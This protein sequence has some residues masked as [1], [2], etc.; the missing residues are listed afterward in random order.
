MEPQ[1]P[2]APGIYGGGAELAAAHSSKPCT[3]GGNHVFL[4]L[5]EQEEVRSYYCIDRNVYFELPEEV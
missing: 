4:T 3:C 1:L 5:D 2:K